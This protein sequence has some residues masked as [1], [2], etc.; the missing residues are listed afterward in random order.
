MVKGSLAVGFILFSLP[1]L[2][3]PTVLVLLEDGSAKPVVGPLQSGLKTK[4]VI[5]KPAGDDAAA[6]LK[7]GLSERPS[8]FGQAAASAGADA[9]LLAAAPTVQGKLAVS[10]QLFAH[11]SGELLAQESVKGSTSE[12]GRVLAPLIKAIAA[13]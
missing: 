3:D 11:T 13:A 8:C 1:A 5:A 12:L 7:L 4:K 2:A 9:L 10:L 6:C